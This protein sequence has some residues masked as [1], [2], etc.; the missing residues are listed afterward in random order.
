MRSLLEQ[1]SLRDAHQNMKAAD[2]RLRAILDAEE[3]NTEGLRGL[4]AAAVRGETSRHQIEHR[5]LVAALA[6]SGGF[7]NSPRTFDVENPLPS[8]SVAR[9]VGVRAITVSKTGEIVQPVF[10]TRPAFEW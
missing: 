4:Y 8:L 6:N 2:R 5:D 10:D 3:P 1:M 9:H 7:L